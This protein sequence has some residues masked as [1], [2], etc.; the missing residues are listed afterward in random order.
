LATLNPK[1]TSI[2]WIRSGCC[3]NSIWKI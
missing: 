1:M 3:A 2:F